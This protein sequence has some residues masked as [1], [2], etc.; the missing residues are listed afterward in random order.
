MSPSQGDTLTT[1]DATHRRRV[2]PQANRRER[3]EA[4]VVAGGR[5]CTPHEVWIAVDPREIVRVLI[6]GP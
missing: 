6:I 3:I 1:G 5:V 4:A 2:P